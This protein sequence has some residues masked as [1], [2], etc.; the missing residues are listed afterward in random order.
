GAC[1]PQN[2]DYYRIPAKKGQR[3][4]IDCT[5]LRIDSRAQVVL[6]LMDPSVGELQSARATKDRDPML[7]FTAAA[8]GPVF[9]RVNDLTFR[10]GDEFQYRLV[11][12]TGPWIDFV[13]PPFLKA[14]A[15]NEV[16]IYGRTLPGG[17]PADH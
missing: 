11:V 2:Y 10:G 13:D 3:Y 17:V 7:D 14:G 6:S 8:D 1:D 5:A 9:L 16:T 12:S 4:V 15:D